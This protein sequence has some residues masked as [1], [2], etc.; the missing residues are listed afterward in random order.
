VGWEA[1]ERG[2]R[3][4]ARSRRVDGRVVREYVGGGLLGEL[5]AAAD[6]AGRRRR[7]EAAAAL[8]AVRER[9]EAA[10]AA[11]AD[12]GA[13]LDGLAAALLVGAGYHQHN[14]GEW[15]KTRRGQEAP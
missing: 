12:F 6:A 11:L 5:A 10:L 3:Y 14:R 9:D 7:A 2:G 1:R 15:R 8:R 4:Y 13:L